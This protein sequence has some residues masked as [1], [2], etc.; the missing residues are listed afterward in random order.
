MFIDLAED[1]SKFYP[2]KATH[3]FLRL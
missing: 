2:L 3:G 1:E